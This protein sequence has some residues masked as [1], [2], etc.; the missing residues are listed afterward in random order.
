MSDRDASTIQV[1]GDVTIDWA[2]LTPSASSTALDS[3]Y[4]WEQLA[5]VH[6]SPLAGSAAF[7]SDLLRAAA[8]EQV[9]RGQLHISGP[10][11]SPEAFSNPA[12]P[13]IARSFAIW[14]QYPQRLGKPQP[15]WRM[16][17]F[18]GLQ[19]ASSA[20]IDQQAVQPSADCLVV[21]DANLGFR[22]DPVRWDALSDAAGRPQHIIVKLSTP[23]AVGPLWDHLIGRFADRLTVYCSVGDLRKEYAPIGQPLSWERTGSDVIDAIRQHPTLTRARRIVVSLGLSGAVIVEPGESSWLVFDPLHQE[24][25]WAR[26]YPGSAPGLGTAVTASLALAA[27]REP[28]SPD[29]ACAVANGLAAGRRMHER[30]FTPSPSRLLFPDDAA[31]L[32]SGDDET[33]FQRCEIS[34]DPEWQ[35]ASSAFQGSERSAAERIVLEGDEVACPN[36]PV[37]RMGV[38][39]SIDRTEI[40]SMRSVRH[41]MRE[42]L[43]QNRP[44][45]P[46]SLAVFGPPGSGK[47]FAIKQMAK[48]WIASGFPIEVLEFNLSQFA[49]GE[50]PRALQRVR[51]CAVEQRLPLVFWDEF[52]T[53]VDGRELGWLAQFLAPMQD[54]MFLEEGMARP[55][56]PAIFIFAGGT[57]AT[58]ESFKERSVDRPAAKASDFLSRLRGF[59]D[60]LGPN[61]SG[62][63]DRSFVLRRALLL[64]S[65]LKLKA[66]QLLNEGVLQIDPGVLRALL[67]VTSYVHGARSMEAILDMSA[68]SGRLRFERSAL[69][70]AHQ[71]GLHV[72]AEEFLALVQGSGA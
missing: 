21:D 47:S 12:D 1:I 17:Q 51:D 32:L 16:R 41:I 38:W 6:M 36:L 52:D 14:E 2:I 18:L 24:G 54:G 55:I 59:V 60:I 5:D 30:G 37:E 57:H 20:S 10:K 46:L 50:L 31:R 25:D 70:P 71:L 23:L 44:R 9:A 7:I 22:D 56:G 15:V 68:L 13:S 27:A 28:G 33:G 45:R 35:I 67:D 26:A 49:A 11:L 43:Q 42:Y 34:G 62:N 3:S 8:R 61:P 64:R 69:P 63:Q 40:E 66:P 65:L 72:D 48:E 4:R 53:A 39:S 29:W 19:P 58:M